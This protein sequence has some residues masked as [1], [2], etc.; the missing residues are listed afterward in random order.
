MNNEHILRKAIES[1][2]LDGLDDHKMVKVMFEAIRLARQDERKLLMNILKDA[3]EAMDLVN[4]Y[5]GRYGRL[6]LFCGANNYDSKVGIIHKDDCVILRIRRLVGGETFSSSEEEKER[7]SPQNLT[8]SA[9][10]SDEPSRKPASEPSHSGDGSGSTAPATTHT[11][12]YIEVPKGTLYCPMCLK[13]VK[14]KD[15]V[16]L[17]RKKERDKE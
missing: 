3:E 2:G 9:R 4:G 7:G 13:L 8:A 17:R 12:M 5:Y 14:K 10:S 1:S 6:C 15:M 16:V 11:C